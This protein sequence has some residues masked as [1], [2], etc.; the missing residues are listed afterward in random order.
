MRI[1]GIG[2]LHNRRSQS[3]A[4]ALHLFVKFSPKWT[5]FASDQDAFESFER[6]DMTVTDL[7][8][9]KGSSCFEKMVYL[10]FLIPFNTGSTCAANTLL[11]SALFRYNAPTTS[12]DRLTP[13]EGDVHLTPTPPPPILRRC[14]TPQVSN[15]ISNHKPHP[16]VINKISNLQWL[17]KP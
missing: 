3:A 10:A 7:F 4:A 6:L 11:Y 16:A 1:R 17:I 8:W 5:G 2:A 15:T 14:F 13:P 12:S 9:Q